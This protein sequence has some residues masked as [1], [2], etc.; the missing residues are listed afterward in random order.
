MDSAGSRGL[1]KLTAKVF[2]TNGASIALFESA[3]FRTVGTHVRHGRLDGEWLDVIL[4]E[5][6]L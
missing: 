1:H 3:G 2:A 6:S 5:R 4:L